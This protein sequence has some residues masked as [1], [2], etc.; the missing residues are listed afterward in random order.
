MDS[1][2]RDAAVELEQDDIALADRM[3][4]G[5]KRIVTELKD[6]APAL[7]LQRGAEAGERIAGLQAP[8]PA[9]SDAIAALVKL[10]YSQMAA[11]EAVAR[12]GHNLG[13]K[14]ALD[15]LIRESLRQLARAV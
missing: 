14:A 12:A 7:A 13:E 8:R 1:L 9:E 6:K 11:G 3:N 10:G 5:R 4:E 2:V 15:V